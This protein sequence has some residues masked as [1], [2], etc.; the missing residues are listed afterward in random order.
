MRDFILQ[1]A[2]FLG[3]SSRLRISKYLN[4][5][6]MT[7][8]KETRSECA[9]LNSTTKLANGYRFFVINDIIMKRLDHGKLVRCTS[10]LSCAV[11]T[12]VSDPQ[13]LPQGSGWSQGA[14][15]SS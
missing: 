2:R 7:V 13:S 14:P 4:S 10:D 6:E 11:S 8:L 1:Q 9:K 3:D 15:P 5:A 12:A